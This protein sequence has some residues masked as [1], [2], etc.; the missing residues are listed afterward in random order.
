MK[1]FKTVFCVFAL[2]STASLLQARAY[3]KDKPVEII[4]HFGI[5]GTPMVAGNYFTRNLDRT[6]YQDGDNYYVSTS[7]YNG[8]VRS[9]GTF[10]AGIDIKFNR[11]IAV[12]VDL[13]L[14][15][16]WLDP[17]TAL[18]DVGTG[19][20]LY[21]IPKAKLYYMD[22]SVVRMYGYVGA[23]IGKYINY[24][25]LQSGVGVDYYDGSVKLEGQFVPFGI[26]FGKKFFGFAELGFGTIF[27]GAQLGFGYR[28]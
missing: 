11:V 3:D 25:G 28:F 15:A 27:L 17:S 16:M 21:L 8:I 19:V 5:S 7:N 10:L 14:N 26:E 20:A 2:L 1:H 12:S 13:G 18:S 9:T 24:P 6:S 22:R 4:A 23:G